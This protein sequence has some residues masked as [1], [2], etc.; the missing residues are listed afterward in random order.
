ML[1][2]VLVVV[3][4]CFDVLAMVVLVGIMLICWCGVG[5]DVDVLVVV[6]AGMLMCWWWC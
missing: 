1:V 4:M 2:V 3:L 5:G 6:L